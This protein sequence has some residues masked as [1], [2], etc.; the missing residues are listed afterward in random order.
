LGKERKDVIMYCREIYRRILTPIAKQRLEKKQ[1]PACGKPKTRWDRRTDW[2][3]CSVDCTEK[4]NKEH[5]KSITW[6]G[7]RLKVLR[8]DD[9]TCKDCG[10]RHVG[11]YERL[12]LDYEKEGYLQV[13]HIMPVA[14]GGDSLD[15]DNLQTLCIDCHK[16][17]TK[18]DM[19][20]ISEFRM[21]EKKQEK[22]QVL[23]IGQNQGKQMGVP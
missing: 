12:K 14:V 11:H 16:E 13:D 7:Q 2:T 20:T 10:V 3:C 22:N 1:C 15:L 4:F 17:K 23:F 8:R 19:K 18:E 21:I 9:Y 6:E 5:D